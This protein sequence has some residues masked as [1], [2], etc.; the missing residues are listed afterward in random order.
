[1]SIT[2]LPLS[3]RKNITAPKIVMEEYTGQLYGGYYDVV[4]KLI[5]AVFNPDWGEQELVSILAH[6]YRHHVQNELGMY[7]QLNS[8]IR[9]DLEYEKQI[10]WY[11]NTFD[12]EMDAL[13]YQN[14][15]AKS[16]TSDWWLRKLVKQ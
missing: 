3:H 9:T 10:K 5:V 15:Y 14:K 11:F 7:K 1:M 6:E 2:W 13:V 8:F 16:E 12:W 4:K